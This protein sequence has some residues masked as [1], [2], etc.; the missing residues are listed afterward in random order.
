MT[1]FQNQTW[2]LIMANRKCQYYIYVK[3][4]YQWLGQQNMFVLH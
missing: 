3:G 4:E 1:I 2:L